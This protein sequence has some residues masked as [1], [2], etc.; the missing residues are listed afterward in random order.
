[1]SRGLTTMDTPNGS[2]IAYAAGPGKTAL[3][4]VGRNSPYTMHLLRHIPVPGRPMEPMFKAVRVEVQRETQ[5]QQT[6]W[7]ASSLTGEFYFVER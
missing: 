6:P 4:G 5:G 3:D 2:L 1:L 7:E